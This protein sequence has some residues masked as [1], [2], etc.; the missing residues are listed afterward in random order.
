MS[1]LFHYSLSIYIQ[2]SSGD[3][4]A[5]KVRLSPSGRHGCS[6]PSLAMDFRPSIRRGVSLSCPGGLSG[7]QW[8]RRLAIRRGSERFVCFNV[9]VAEGDK[10]FNKLWRLGGKGRHHTTLMIS[11]VADVHYIQN[12]VQN[13]FW[14]SIEILKTRHKGEIKY[15]W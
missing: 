10:V 1:H 2:L 13:L 7:R 9:S 5:L 3:S 15:Q 11:W 14:K 4:D 6:T 12:S 8:I